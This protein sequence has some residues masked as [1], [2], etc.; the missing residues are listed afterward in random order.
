MTARGQLRHHFW[1]DYRATI[2]LD[3]GTPQLASLAAPLF[4]AWHVHETHPEALVYFGG[5]PEL[6]HELNHL[7]RLGADRRKVT[8]VA[9]SIDFGDPFTITVNPPAD[10]TQTALEF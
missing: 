7:Y 10:A 3:F 4:P 5:D 1:L 2:V 8:S 9:H 6:Q